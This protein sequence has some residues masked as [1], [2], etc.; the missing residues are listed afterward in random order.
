MIDMIKA[1]LNNDRQSMYARYEPSFLAELVSVWPDS[2][3]G[4]RGITPS[5]LAKGADLNLQ[6][7][8]NYLDKENPRFPD[9]KAR[10]KLGRFFKI[11][12]VD[13][14]DNHVDNSKVLENIKALLDTYVYGKAVS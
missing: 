11:Y 10:E 1:G 12:F 14:W 8:L 2:K 7:V 9:S 13:D 4:K 6:T 5:S 3:T